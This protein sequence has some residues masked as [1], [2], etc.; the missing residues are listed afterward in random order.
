MLCLYDLIKGRS[1]ILE[2]KANGD[3]NDIETTIEEIRK[4]LQPK[5]EAKQPETA[6]EVAPEGKTTLTL[7]KS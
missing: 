6:N 2:R 5:Q 4:E 7:D 3:K 1:G